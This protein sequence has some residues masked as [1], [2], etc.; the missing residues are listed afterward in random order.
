MINNIMSWERR[1]EIEDEAR[2]N[3][4]SISYVETE[5]ASK[6]TG[7]NRFEIFPLKEAPIRIPQPIYIWFPKD[8]YQD[9]NVS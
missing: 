8:N 4:Q 7:E 6:S 3:H 5:K 1:L 2:K 9:Q